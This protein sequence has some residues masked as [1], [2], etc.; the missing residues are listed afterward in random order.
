MRK[1]K[2]AVMAALLVICASSSA[3]ARAAS[4]S[5]RDV[6]TL[7]LVVGAAGVPYGPIWVALANNMFAK[8]GV[9]VNVLSFTGIQTGAAEL[10]AGQADLFA[11]ST[12]VGVQ[13]SAQG[14]PATAVYALSSFTAYMFAWMTKS[15]ITSLQQLQN[16]GTN[17]KVAEGLAGSGG[18]AYTQEFMKANGLKCSI[19]NVANPTAAA[20]V[21][22]SGQVD[23]GA[24]FPQDG[25]AATAAGTGDVLVDPSK[26]TPAQAKAIVPDPFLAVG[27]VGLT[28]DL[29]AKKSAVVA[30]IRT[31]RQAQ[32]M[33]LRTSPAQLAQWTVQ[34]PGQPFGTTPVD[35]L[36]ST[37]AVTIPTFPTGPTAGSILPGAWAASLA[38][39]QNEFKTPGFDSTSTAAQY[40]N[41]VDMSYFNAAGIPI[42]PKSGPVIKGKATVGQ[43]L[44]IT[45]AKWSIAPTAVSYQWQVCSGKCADIKGAK[46][47]T[48]KIQSSFSGK[49][50]R[51]VASAISST[52]NSARVI[53]TRVAVA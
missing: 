47:A 4:T 9:N 14:Q 1:L 46:T 35:L 52:G 12:A 24:V 39:F 44:K 38:G 40:A 5:A 32:T 48:L 11:S 33:M 18:F 22:E 53:S 13:L 43:T 20:Q 10:V 30:F 31:L 16:M 37:W 21:V 19:V 50:L 15:G 3:Q 17:C 28:S 34:V 49:K 51:I 36:T 29:T 6:P 42:A 41:A 8:N 25:A 27:I 23:A 45:P 2:Y 26:M 7:N